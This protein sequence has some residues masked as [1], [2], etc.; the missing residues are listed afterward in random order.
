MSDLLRR[1]AGRYKQTEIGILPADWHV[2]ELGKIGQ[3]IIGLTYS[4]KDVAEHGSLV[5]RS[6]NVQ[7]NK[8]AFENNVFV[9]MELPERVIVKEGDILLCVRNGSRH[10]IGKCA[11]IDKKTEGSAFGAFMSIYRSPSNRFLFY[12]FQSDSIQRQISEIMGATIN[13]ITNKDMA[14]F[15]AALPPRENEKT[16]IANA[17]SDVDA[18]ITSLEKL[19]AKKRA[20]KTAAMQQLL[21]GKKRL[22]PFD[23]THSGY[24]Q[25]ELGEIPK[26][27]EVVNLLDV[28]N[29]I[30]GKAHEPYVVNAG[31]FVVVNSKFVSTE[32][33]VRK[34]CSQ[35]D[36]PAKIG[37]VLMVLSDLPN[38]KAL[39]KCYLVSE[40]RIYA[41]NQRVC[42][43]RSKRIDPSFLYYAINRHDYFLR[44]DDGVTQTHILNGDI[45]GCEFVAPKDRSE[46]KAIG[47]ILMD[48]NKDI[49]GLTQR[50]KKS[51][52][53]KQGVM[54]E[55]L[56]G[57]T[58][59]L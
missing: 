57:R 50:L 49:D 53:L 1:P 33:R 23:K 44:L 36:C 24:Q 9:E 18:L 2:I 37:D 40:D 27:W 54:Q 8:L 17:L 13:Q 34:F 45:A 51:Q 41:V 55:L 52:Q 12:Q 20:I 28:A 30:H 7:N 15:K 48:M 46:Q 58:R 39:A 25:T 10:L 59:L 38:G 6:S 35:N 29:L 14:A 26:D 5:L 22:P 3:T 31:Q 32:G 19:I 47:E 43:Y 4:P 56:T 42:I 16:A 11:L 21:T